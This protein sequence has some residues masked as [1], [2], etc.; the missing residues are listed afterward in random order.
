MTRY[1]RRI[2]FGVFGL[3][4]SA[5]A[6]A[7]AQVA[8]LGKGWLLDSGGSITSAPGEVISGRNSIRASG[9]SPVGGLVTF[10]L[11]TDS[12]FV[13][14]PPNQS[15]TMA[16]S[17][18]IITADGGGF[19]YGFQSEEGKGVRDF[20]PDAVLRGASGSSGTVSTPFRLNNHGDYHVMFSIDGRGSIVI[21][22]IRITDASGQLVAS[23]NA[24]GPTIAPGPLDFQL[25][26]AITVLTPASASVRSV[27][28]KDLDGDGY[29]ETILTLTAPP[30]STT[31]LA[32]IVIESSARMR[33][34]RAPSFQVVRRR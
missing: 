27:T 28:V 9:T 19:G 20:G 34:P 11:E 5:A 29:Q 3:L 15:Y 17:Y 4:L 23:E 6:S 32:P 18:R 16:F 14:L 21:D 1:K 2:S 10:F 12:T 13:R 24:E 7:H 8:S 31:P 33:S 22:D 26:D 30:P 25:T